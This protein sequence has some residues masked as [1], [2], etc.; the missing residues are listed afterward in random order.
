MSIVFPF[1]IIST[2]LS[3]L[4]IEHQSSISGFLLGF[5][6]AGLSLAAV[7][8]MIIATM[9]TEIISTSSL[10]HRR[11]YLPYVEIGTALII[12]AHFCGVGLMTVFVQV[13]HNIA[14][15]VFFHWAI[16][17]AAIIGLIIA[18]LNWSSTP[19]LSK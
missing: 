3:M 10:S 9:E 2:I 11:N 7:M 8:P 4:F 14:T 5:C 18:F 16:L 6:T 12:G 13:A 1:L 15:N 19:K 17:I